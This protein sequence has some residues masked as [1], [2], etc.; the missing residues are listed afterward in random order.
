MEFEQQQQQLEDFLSSPEKIR[1][2]AEKECSVTVPTALATESLAALCRRRWL[3]SGSVIS[4]P[5]PNRD[6]LLFF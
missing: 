5:P 6:W 2:G 4:E 1:A 3:S